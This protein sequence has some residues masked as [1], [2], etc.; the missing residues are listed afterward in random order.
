MAVKVNR[1]NISEHLLEYQL[2]LIGKTV[3]DAIIAEEYA[4]K[5]WRSYFLFYTQE[6]ADKFRAY[7]IPLIKKV[8]KCNKKRAEN[9]FDWFLLNFGLTV[10]KTS[11]R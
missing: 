9:I 6:H 10:H 11:T 2:S 3:K 5:S 7:A 4:R 1:T 8:F